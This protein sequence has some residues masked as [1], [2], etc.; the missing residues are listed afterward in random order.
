MISRIL[1]PIIKDEALANVAAF[2]IKVALVYCTWRLLKYSGETYPGFLWGG[3]SA[4]YDLMGSLLTK[5]DSLILRLIDVPH[6]MKHRL[7]IIEGTRGIYFADLCLGIAPM[8][9]FS[10]IILSVGNNWR[11]RLWFIPLGL[12]LIYIINVFRL[13]ALLLLQKK[14]NE[15]FD[16]AHD[17]LYVTITYS[18][19]F[20]LVVWWTNRLAFEENEKAK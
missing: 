4:F 20:L 14:S 11:N 19:I 12:I 1:K 16:F 3:W 5:T 10:G 2:I 7:I 8:F 18:L 17:Y 15:L 13:L 6:I 9:I